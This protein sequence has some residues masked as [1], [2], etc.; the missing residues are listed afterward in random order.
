MKYILKCCVANKDKV[1]FVT[2]KLGKRNS[3]IYYAIDLIYG[4]TRAVGFK[5]IKENI[6]DIGNAD[7]CG[8]KLYHRNPTITFDKDIFNHIHTTEKLAKQ[9]NNNIIE[10]NSLLTNLIQK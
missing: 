1:G 6:K 4:E 3:N 8:S 10:S 9:V 7:I 5:W 2:E